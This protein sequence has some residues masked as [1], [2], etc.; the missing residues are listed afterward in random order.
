LVIAVSAVLDIHSSP[1]ALLK[2]LDV[3]P[4][5]E[6]CCDNL[7]KKLPR[8]DHESATDIQRLPGNELRLC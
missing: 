8:L 4:G 7:R 2:D 1:S 3:A 5:E 6:R